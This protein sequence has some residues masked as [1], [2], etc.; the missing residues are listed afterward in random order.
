MKS[1]IL[2][3][4]DVEY[5]AINALRSTH[6][7]EFCKSPAL[8][9]EMISGKDSS[10]SNRAFA[11]GRLIH[12]GILEPDTVK[13]SFVRANQK[14]CRGAEFMKQAHILDSEGKT[15]LSMAEFDECSA[16]VGA[17]KKNPIVLS[18]LED[19]FV[20]LAAVATIE[21]VRCKIKMD[22]YKQADG[23]AWI[24]DL[25]STG[26]EI[27]G[28]RYAVD[29]FGY[30]I[31]G[32]FYMLVAEEAFKNSE[33][34]VPEFFRLIPLTKKKPYRAKRFDLVKRMDHYKEF[35]RE[36][37]QEFKT[38]LDSDDWEDTLDTEIEEL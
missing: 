31:S 18:E 33:Y 24:T 38:C 27:E 25:K 28:F 14:T 10:I 21:G 34:A 20:E 2:K 36:K 3:V 23:R 12:A 26:K 17:A 4:S 22:I 5:G 7:K 13:T 30:Y 11:K 8:F 19:S 15:L 32:A 1:Q 16:V 35:V 9:K 37:L 29:D 6:F